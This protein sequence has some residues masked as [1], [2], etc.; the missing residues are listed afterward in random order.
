[1]KNFDKC[2]AAYDNQFDPLLELEYDD[3]EYEECEYHRIELVEKFVTHANAQTFDD[4]CQ[5]YVN[6]DPNAWLTKL[7][8]FEEGHW[9]FQFVTDELEALTADVYPSDDEIEADA[10]RGAKAVYA[11]TK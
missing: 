9:A 4:L 1:M 10:E 7:I 3:S 2:Q 6:G 5:G 11:L 8:G